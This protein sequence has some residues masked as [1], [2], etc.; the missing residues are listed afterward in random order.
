MSL[1]KEL[2]E[3]L[4][5]LFSVLGGSGLRIQALLKLHVKDITFKG[6]KKGKIRV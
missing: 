3:K 4:R 6:D 5:L 1:K 2:P